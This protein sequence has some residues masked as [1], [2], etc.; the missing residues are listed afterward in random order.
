MNP[1]DESDAFPFLDEVKRNKW[2]KN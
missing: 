2:L 1:L